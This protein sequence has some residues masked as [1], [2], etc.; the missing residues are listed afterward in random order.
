MMV[1]WVKL[2]HLF[3]VIQIVT[4]A[5]LSNIDNSKT[6]TTVLEANHYFSTTNLTTTYDINKIEVDQSL[7]LILRPK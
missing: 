5:K 6:A 4:A 1:K 2:L 3:I 7:I